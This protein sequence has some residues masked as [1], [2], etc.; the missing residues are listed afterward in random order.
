MSLGGVKRKLKKVI[1]NNSNQVYNNNKAHR[2]TKQKKEAR[3]TK[4][5]E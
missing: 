2:K 5:Q 3:E 4:S 1:K